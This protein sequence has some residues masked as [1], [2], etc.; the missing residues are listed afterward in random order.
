MIFT[1]IGGMLFALGMCM[2]LLPEWDAYIPGV[3]MAV[4]GGAV[5]TITF[6]V[7]CLVFGDHETK[8]NGKLLGKT[9]FGVFG[10]LVMGVGMCMVMV[11]DLMIPGIIIGIAGLVLL[12]CLIPM[13][14]GLK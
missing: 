8:F 2:C 4:I 14:V 7:R 5:M 9:A 10:A 1:V 3:V 11:F 12:L 6:L 13:C